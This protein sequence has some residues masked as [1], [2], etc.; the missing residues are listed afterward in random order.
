M[1]NAQETP[2]QELSGPQLR[3]RRTRTRRKSKIYID[4]SD[5]TDSGELQHKAEAKPE[6]LPSR[7]SRVFSASIQTLLSLTPLRSAM[8]HFKRVRWPPS[9]VIIL[10][11]AR[12]FQTDQDSLSIFLKLRTANRYS[13]ILSWSLQSIATLWRMFCQSCTKFSC[14]E[15]GCC[16]EGSPR[17]GGTTSATSGDGARAKTRTAYVCFTTSSVPLTY[18]PRQSAGMDL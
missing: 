8:L 13:Y 15:S 16:C 3:S 10:S 1:P 7:L 11:I 18:L 14:A 17:I 12:P 9:G 4:D 5:P 6:S 2:R